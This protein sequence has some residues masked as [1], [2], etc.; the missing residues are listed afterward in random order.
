MGF[1]HLTLT[2][3][4]S[5]LCTIV[6]PWG[7]YEYLRLP[8]GLCNSPDLFQEHMSE[9]MA[10]LEFVKVYIDDILC[11]T[12][13]DFK[14]HL[15]KL[16]EV[17]MRIEQAGLRINAEKS[18]FAKPEVDYLGFHI[19]RKGIQPM[20]KKVDAIKA[21]QPPT[22]RKQLRHFIGLV[23][24]Y[25]D[26]WPRRSEILAPLSKLSSN[27]IPFKWTEVEQKAF[28]KMKDVISKDVLLTYPNFNK[29]FEIHTDASHT[30]LGSVISQDGKLI[31]FY[32]RK[33]NPAQTRYTTTERELLSIVETLKEFRNILYGHQ[34]LIYTDH[35]NL[36][37]KEFNTERV[38]RW[39]LLIEEYHPILKYIKGSANIVADAL[40]R[41]NIAP[42]D[43]VEN[44]YS[45]YTMAENFAVDDLPDDAF[46][47]RCST[48]DECQ[49]KDDKLLN[50]LRKG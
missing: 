34:I 49:Q 47:L 46:P 37:H 26:M 31:A 25:R 1:Y 9:L 42:N 50:N 28:D 22:T 13:S 29:P 20:P 5:R 7:K 35:K 16:E 48:I 10:G 40:S 6:M 11:L 4:A 36:T 33:L 24:Y 27:K 43:P 32:S 41:L 19:N 15:R 30:Q 14:D 44:Q 2:P 17:F 18:F 21:I 38:M 45:L 12:K 3:N 39:R 23:N 8:M